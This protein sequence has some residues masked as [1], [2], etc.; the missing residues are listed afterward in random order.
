MHILALLKRLASKFKL[1]H[2]GDRKRIR[3]VYAKLLYRK[4]SIQ[5]LEQRAMMAFDLAAGSPLSLGA[6]NPRFIEAADFNR[7]GIQDL[8]T[9]SRDSS[10]IS[11]ALGFGGGQFGVPTTTSLTNRPDSLKAADFN[12]DGILDLV[13]GGFLTATHIGILLGT[14]SGGFGAPSFIDAGGLFT[15]G[16]TVADL[17]GDGH[18]DLATANYSSDSISILLGNGTGAFAAATPLAVGARPFSIAASDFDGNSTLDLAIG[19]FGSDNLTIC[20]ASATG[21]SRPSVPQYQSVMPH[22]HCD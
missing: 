5:I 22:L 3:R 12:E 8:A 6:N 1:I 2:R 13:V 17:N 4:A 7:D 14:G 18:L 15:T 19:N 16:V 9:T 11:V 21:L 10:N 20:P